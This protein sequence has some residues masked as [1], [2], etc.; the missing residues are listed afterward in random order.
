MHCKFGS[1]RPWSRYK[2][3]QV[4]RGVVRKPQTRFCLVCKNTFN[5]LGLEDKYG[6]LACYYK[7]CAK[8][9]N[10]HLSRT[11]VKMVALFI[12][13]QNDPANEGQIQLKL[14]TV[15]E[16][17]QEHQKLTT[18]QI[19]AIDFIDDSTEFVSKEA[20][21]PELDGKWDQDKAVHHIV[22][23]ETKEGAWVQRGRP[24]VRAV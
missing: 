1:T 22:F 14:K 5:A 3:M 2:A 7:H 17:A 20:W 4:A 24:G 21:N 11:F 18:A 8:V 15:K 10:A 9:E 13:M 6:T 16:M 12:K 23:G 19:Q